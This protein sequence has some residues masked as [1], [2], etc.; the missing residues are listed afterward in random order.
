MQEEDTEQS[1]QADI[2][3]SI[4]ETKEAEEEVPD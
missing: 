4:W 3:Q 2:I 1:N